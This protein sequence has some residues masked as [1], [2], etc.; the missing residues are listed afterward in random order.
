MIKRLVIG[1]RGSK[2]ALAQTELVAD[3]LRRA[4]GFGIEIE[5]RVLMTSGDSSQASG[6]PLPEI[7]G[8]GLFTAELDAA[9]RAGEIDLAVHSLKDLPVEADDPDAGLV[10]AALIQRARVED[11]LITHSHATLGSLPSG[12]RIGTS[13]PRRMAQLLATRSDLAPMSIRG[14]IDTR[15]RKL[16]EG[17]YEAIVLAGCGLD[18]LGLREA[19]C[20][21]LGLEVMLPAPGQ[22]ALAVQCRNDNA[23][24][25][26]ALVAIDHQP[27]R[28]A[29]TAERAFLRNLGGG[30]SLPVAALGTVHNH[31]NSHQIHLRGRVC[32]AAGVMLDAAQTGRDPHTLGAE[33]ARLLIER[34]ALDMLKESTHQGGD[35]Q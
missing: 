34:G 15:L 4:C 6:M 17:Q 10:I 14:N 16:H 11:V 21:T 26:A 13:S 1:T 5:Q 28:L 29:V 25:R 23:V 3:A 20:E 24:M 27:T 8:K 31:D 33:L 7:G 19:H 2:L 35:A 12:A 18:R 9:L 22:G 30:C 32:G